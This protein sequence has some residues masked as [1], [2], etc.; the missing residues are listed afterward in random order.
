MNLQLIL[1]IAGRNVDIMRDAILE[2][3]YHRS[4]NAHCLKPA[5]N[6]MQLHAQIVGPVQLNVSNVTLLVYAL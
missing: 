1:L 4:L 3:I 6:W 2:H 5:P